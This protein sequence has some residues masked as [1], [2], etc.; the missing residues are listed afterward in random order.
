MRLISIPIII[1]ILVVSIIQWFGPNKG[2]AEGAI[3]GNIIWII[4]FMADAWWDE[5]KSRRRTNGR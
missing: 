4:I 2:F 1:T 5:W 3:A